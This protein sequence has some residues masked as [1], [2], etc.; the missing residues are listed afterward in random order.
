MIENLLRQLN[1]HASADWLASQAPWVANLLAALA[2]MLVGRVVGIWLASWVRRR[3]ETRTHNALLA[4]LLSR[5]VL[6]TAFVLVVSV[7]FSLM[8]WASAAASLLAGAG[9]TGI[10]L[11]FAFKEI[12]EDFLSGILMAF[13]RPFLVGDAVSIGGPVGGT[14]GVVMDVDLRKTTLTAWDGTCVFVPNGQVVNSVVVN[15]SRNP[16]RRF[17]FFLRV[18]PDVNFPAFESAILRAL[19]SHPAVDLQQNPCIVAPE[20]QEEGSLRV[21]VLYWVNMPQNELPVVQL[22]GIVYA[23][24][25]LALRHQGFGLAHPRL[26]LASSANLA[27]T[28]TDEDRSNPSNSPSD[29]L[30]DNF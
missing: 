13:D 2:V 4:G 1:L 17:E 6:G 5:I 25:V 14:E 27:R 20:F 26:E 18:A 24:V 16:L 8:G 28:R 22:R 7:V 9:V 21:R 3:V 10:I 29:G 23:H 19:A 15:Y 30:G 11:G 12:V